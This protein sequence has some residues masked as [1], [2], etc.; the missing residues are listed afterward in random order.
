MMGLRLG[1]D[2]TLPECVGYADR[3]PCVRRSIVPELRIGNAFR[4]VGGLPDIGM[5]YWDATVQLHDGKVEA[6]MFS[7]HHYKWLDLK[8]LLIERYGKPL[9]VDVEK[10]Q[11]KGG[12]SITGQYL[13]WRGSRTKITAN[14]Y[15]GDIKTSSVMFVSVEV[16]R[17]AES[18]RAATARKGAG[19]L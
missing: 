17:Q 16:E 18:A 4:E 6:F 11:M 19:K 10:L 3:E 1:A 9:V 5:P 15:S 8:A 7:T 13:M 12:I 2:L 14:E